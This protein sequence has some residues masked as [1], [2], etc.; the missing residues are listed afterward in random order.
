MAVS[1]FLVDVNTQSAVLHQ[2]LILGEAVKRLSTG[3]KLIHGSAL[4]SL[5]PL[6]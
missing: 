6:A 1:D 4:E 5:I 3:F 2:L